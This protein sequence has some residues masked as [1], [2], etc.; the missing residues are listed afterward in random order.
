[1][2]SSVAT[3]ATLVLAHAKVYTFAC[4]AMCRALERFAL[5]QLEQLLQLKSSYALP[6]LTEAVHHI[7]ENTQG[8]ELILEPARQLFIHSLAHHVEDLDGCF[9]GLI[10]SDEIMAD[11]FSEVI[12]RATTAEASCAEKDATI[13]TIRAGRCRKC[14]SLVEPPLA[15][16]VEWN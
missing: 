4:Q 15:A 9:E 1:M 14:R 5:Q 16:V 6:H 10:G 3:P 13:D 2:S 12:K 8:R 11:L 7:Y